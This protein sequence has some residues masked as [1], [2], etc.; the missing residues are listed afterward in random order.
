M[1][2]SNKMQKWCPRCQTMKNKTEF[3]KHQKRHDGLQSH[4]R[5]CLKEQQKL[6]AKTDAGK[7]KIQKYRKKHKNK[8]LSYGKEYRKKNR[9]KITEYEK[10]RILTDENFKIRK[11]MR[12]IVIRAIKRVSNNN[13]KY[14]STITQIGCD[15]QF[16][17]QHIENQF[18]RGMSWTNHGKWHIDHIKPCASFDLTDPEQQ[19]LCNHYSNLQPLWKKD[20]LKKR[21]KVN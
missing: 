15:D 2:K 1:I 6:W 19:K 10:N 21:D 4:C 9:K 8:L 5:E 20:N 3:N 12:S 13:T 7:N 17:K 16:F 11:L 18:K 14:S